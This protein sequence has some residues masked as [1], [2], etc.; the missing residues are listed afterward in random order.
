M[1]LK[2]HK[3]VS[4]T[5]LILLSYFTTFGQ[6]HLDFGGG[7]ENIMTGTRDDNI[8]VMKISVGYEF[9]KIVSEAIIQPALTH[10]VNTPS[11]FG[12]K[13][14]FNFHNLVPSVGYLYN[15]RN[16]DNPEKNGWQMGYA[17]KYQLMLNDKGGLYI[18]T[19][20]TN[21]TYELTAGFH[22]VFQ[23]NQNRK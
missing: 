15:Y 11:Y 14:G 18:E 16:S 3:S 7:A 23:K 2:L 8:P 1:N 9:H 10:R 5:I 13:I 6:A 21:S 4:L 20:Y 22:V 17:L 19:M 12:I